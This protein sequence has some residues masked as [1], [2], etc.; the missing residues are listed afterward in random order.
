MALFQVGIDVSRYQGSINWSAVAAAGK[1]F[2][3][4]R[5]GSSNN[6]GAYVD[7]YFLQNVN[8]AHAAGL[9][10][11]AYYYTYARTES[12]VARELTTFLNALEG[13]QLEYPVFV[14][15]EARSLTSLG[16]PQLTNL[17]KY[18]MDILNQRKW[19]AGWYSYTNYIN[20]YMLPRWQTI[21][22]GWRITAPAWGTPGGTACGSIPVP[23]PSAALP[24]RWI[25][26]TAIRTICPRYAPG[27][28][29]GM[30]AMGRT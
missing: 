13:L 12:A 3:I 17:V 18:A 30:A 7:P 26:I 23:A 14:D 29:T 10:V 19:Y 6:N 22:F 1:Q 16:K 2:A 20:S 15:V 28:L 11:G 27:I 21:R 9:R 8:G 24:A 4:V 25:W 5:I